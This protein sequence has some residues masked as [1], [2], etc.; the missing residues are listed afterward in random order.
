MLLCD[1]GTSGVFVARGAPAPKPR[2]VPWTPPDLEPD[3]CQRETCR[4]LA[5]DH[6]TLRVEDR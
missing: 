3:R 2:G 6:S 1:D 4:K 5:M